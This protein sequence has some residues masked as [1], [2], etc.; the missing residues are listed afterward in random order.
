[1]F[2]SDHHA[3]QQYIRDYQKQVL[4]EKTETYYQ[5]YLW[6]RAAI[7]TTNDTAP[8]F[9][10]H[11][12]VAMTLEMKPSFKVKVKISMNVDTSEVTMLLGDFLFIP[13][14]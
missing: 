13:L 12:F 11:C 4:S 8:F 2:I 1:M 14:D 9:S 10:V 3:Y 5:I 6:E 7:I